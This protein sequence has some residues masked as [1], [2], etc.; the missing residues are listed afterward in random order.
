VQARLVFEYTGKHTV[1]SLPCTLRDDI[2]EFCNANGSNL[3]LSGGAVW[4]KMRINLTHT[5]DLTYTASTKFVKCDTFID[6][7]D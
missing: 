1:L 7:I 2:L 3:P 4:N 6:D 5:L